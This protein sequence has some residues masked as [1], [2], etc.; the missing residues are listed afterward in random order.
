MLW[1]EGIVEGCSEM[2]WRYWPGV[3]VWYVGIGKMVCS[4][5]EV[6]IGCGMVVFVVRYVGILL[7]W[8][9]VVLFFISGSQTSHFQ[10]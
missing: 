9:R 4:F 5:M 6:F 7:V 10:S 2:V 3:G 8:L 1:H